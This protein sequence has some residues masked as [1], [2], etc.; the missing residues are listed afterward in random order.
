MELNIR[1]LFVAFSKQGKHFVAYSPALDLSTSGS[2]KARA[3]KRFANIVEPFF[4]EIAEAGTTHALLTE[5]GWQRKG[6]KSSWT[7]PAF[8]SE[9]MSLRVPIVA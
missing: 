3:A 7:P 2:T 1:N 8:S 4:E 9:N 6:V 5:L